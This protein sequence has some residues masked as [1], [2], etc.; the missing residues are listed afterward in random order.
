MALGSILFFSMVREGIDD[1]KKH[2]NDTEM[3]RGR[4]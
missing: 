2:K 4:T 3:N 1:F